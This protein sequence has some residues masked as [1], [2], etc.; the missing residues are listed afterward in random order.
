MARRT[1]EE[2]ETTREEILDAA[3]WCFS[4]YG[5]SGTSLSKIA[6][7]TGHSRG[8]IY[9]HFRGPVEL[10]RAVIERGQLPI[11]EQLNLACGSE[12]GFVSALRVCL[13]ANFNLIQSDPNVRGALTI[14]AFRC[15][16]SG[17]LV[18][19]LED[20]R[21]FVT[22]LLELLQRLLSSAV[23]SGELKSHTPVPSVATSIAYS[24]LGS[25]RVHLLLA[26]ESSL[27]QGGMS[28]VD[29]ALS[30]YLVADS[31]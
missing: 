13:L 27:T 20:Q 6:A 22:R 11:L 3:V 28:A 4:R 2:S 23:D 29:T 18:Q 26:T 21:A 12:S 19:L 16:F 9:W 31:G 5:T 24:V 30:A 10:L 15:D 1:K 25:M 7:R 17:D 8:A 14:Q